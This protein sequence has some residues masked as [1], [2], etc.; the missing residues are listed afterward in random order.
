MPQLVLFRVLQGIGAGGVQPIANTIVGDLY[1]REERGRMQGLISSVY[2]ISAVAGPSLGSFLVQYESWP[3]VFWI[4]LPICLTAS[5]LIMRFLP[6]IVQDRPHRVDYLGSLLLMFAVVSVMLALHTLVQ[7]LMPGHAIGNGVALGGTSIGVVALLLLIRHERKTPDPILPLDLWRSRVIAVGCLGGGIA[8]ALMMGVAAFLPPYVQGVMGRNA[9]IAGFVLGTMS[10]LWTVASVGAGSLLVHTSYRVAAVLGTLLLLVGTLTLIVMTPDSGPIWAA[11]G[12]G[13]IGVGM[14][15][16]TTTFIVSI[17]S[18][19]D[20]HQR[21]AATSS[22]MFLRCMGQ[23]LGVALFGGVVN[24]TIALLDPD[25]S[26]TVNQLMH[27]KQRQSLSTEQLARLTDVMATSIHYAFLL[28]GILALI[29]FGL[30][31]CLP[32]KLSPKNQT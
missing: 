17:Q 11:T 29:A 21:G 26:A 2:C 4:N 22:M 13:L 10:V 27:V 12:S 14:G 9:S 18:A 15:L 5:A 24:L 6:E 7:D 19:V 25:V 31:W 23:A 3:A 30:A 28:A 16:C 20:W 1:S 8:G 32:T